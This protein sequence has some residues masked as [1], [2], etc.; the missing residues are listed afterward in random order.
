MKPIHM[1]FV[2]LL[3]I[4]GI[5]G[6]VLMS[7][8]PDGATG[9]AHESIPALSV[10][11]DG[12]AKL[13]TIGKAPYYFQIVVIL[14]AGTLLYM[15][16]AQHRRDTLL[17]VAFAAGTG[18]AL[19]VW[20]MLWTGYEGYLATGQTEVIFG[21]PVPTN[22]MFWGIWGSFALFD[23]FYVLTFRRYILPHEDEEAFNELVAELKA[24]KGDS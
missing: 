6:F 3:L 23:L 19:F 22:W 20:I 12:A 11:G 16:I 18:F 9:V 15:G 7:E 8:V 13:A 2:L 21:F 24:E 17:K 10:G 14:L 4:A 5:T 1:V